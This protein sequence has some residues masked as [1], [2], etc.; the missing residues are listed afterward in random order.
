MQFS[1]DITFFFSCTTVTFL[2][3]VPANLICL[4]YLLLGQNLHCKTRMKNTTTLIFRFIFTTDLLL[5]LSVSPFALQQLSGHVFYTPARQ[6]LCELIEFSLDT[7]TRLVFFLMSMLAVVRARAIMNPL[8]PLAWASARI[9]VRGVAFF[10]ILVS[11]IPVVMRQIHEE[12]FCGGKLEDTFPNELV[13][14]LWPGLAT[15]LPVAVS[16]VVMLGAN[17]VSLYFL[18]KRNSDLNHAQSRQTRNSAAKMTL[19]LTTI[20]FSLHVLGIVTSWSQVLHVPAPVSGYIANG[21]IFLS[22]VVDPCLYFLKTPALKRFYKNRF[23]NRVIR[24]PS[25]ARHRRTPPPPPRI[26]RRQR[27]RQLLTA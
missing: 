18:L 2:V 8:R 21:A 17:M 9:H 1:V 22:V 11:L 7:L 10:C 26:L 13:R 3:G 15:L 19:M 23:S 4:F 25:V 20:F 12:A 16:V 5:A 27:R 24:V 14:T 6:W